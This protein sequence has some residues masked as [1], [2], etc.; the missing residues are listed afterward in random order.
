MVPSLAN[1]VE[2]Q[3]YLEQYTEANLTPQFTRVGIGG[4]AGSEQLCLS[5]DATHYASF[6]VDAG[7]ITINA[8]GASI[9]NETGADT[10]FRI[11]GK[12]LSHML[13]LDAS[14]A[15][16]NIA[17]CAGSAPDWQ[18]MDRGIFLGD[19]TTLPSANASGGVF[20]YSNSETLTVN[21]G[22]W[23]LNKAGPATIQVG[24]NDNRAGGLLLYGDNA[25]QG[26]YIRLYADTAPVDYFG[27]QSL[28]GVMQIGLD[29][30]TDIVLCAAGKVG[31]GAAPPSANLD[32]ALMSTGVLCLTETTTPTAD[33]NYGKVYTK[34]T[35][36][37]FFQ[38]GAGVEHEI[39]F[40]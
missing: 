38:D 12:T 15:T 5:Y 37:L 2:V 9:F 29:D 30:A 40:V 35:N 26:G 22:L 17:L 28:S 27:I 19:A 33:T 7:G 1:T 6:I 23:V 31:L 18:S 10:D 24:I 8:I 16:E 4:P 11:E 13:F 3:R 25:S 36:K 39:A 32:L 20:L 34:N 14:A 21:P